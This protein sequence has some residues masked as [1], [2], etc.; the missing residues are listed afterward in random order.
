MA[1]RVKPKV[2]INSEVL[3]TLIHEETS[4]RKIAKAIGWSDRTIR[5]GLKDGEM[6]IE[7]ILLLSHV[8]SIEPY[9]FADIDGF[10][11]LLKSLHKKE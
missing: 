8:L 3:S 11:D 10:C 9:E 2:K 1:N 5:Q 7:I 4:I 6:S